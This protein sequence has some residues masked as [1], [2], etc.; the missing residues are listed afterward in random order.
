MSAVRSSA[1]LLRADL[2]SAGSGILTIPAVLLV[3]YCGLF[4]INLGMVLLTA[5][6][7]L[8]SLAAFLSAVFG[9][10][11]APVELSPP[12]AARRGVRAGMLTLLVGGAT[13]VLLTTFLS[14]GF[15]ESSLVAVPALAVLLPI[16][17][18]M[19]LPVLLAAMLFGWLGGWLE[20]QGR[21]APHSSDQSDL[22][23]EPE[24]PTTKP[25]LWKTA[26][27]YIFIVSGLCYASPLV[28]L[29]IPEP[30]EEIAVEPTPP[31]PE[32]VPPVEPERE[33]PPP[34]PPPYKYQRPAGFLEAGAERITI[35]QREDYHGILTN[36][37]VSISP[38][39]AMLAFCHKRLR[40]VSV[41]VIRLDDRQQVVSIPLKDLPIGLAW[42]QDSQRLLYIANG[43][44]RIAGV[45]SLEDAS[46]IELPIPY[47]QRLPNQANMVWPFEKQVA[48]FAPRFDPA[49][50]DLDT[51]RVH[52]LIDSEPWEELS[53]ERKLVFQAMARGDH[54][55][56]N[57][58]L[59][60]PHEFVSYYMPPNHFLG[61]W[62]QRTNGQMAVMD[63]EFAYT[64]ILPFRIP[65]R[66]DRLIATPDRSIFVHLHDDNAQ[67]L[68]LGLRDAPEL[69]VSVPITDLFPEPI[70]LEVEN[71]L[72]NKVLAAFVC[73]PV[74]N[75]L[76]NEVV[77]PDRRR[78]RAM[79]R[80]AMLET[81]K[82]EL[83]ISE[84][85]ERVRKGDVVADLHYWQSNQ[86]HSLEDPR[87]ED[88]WKP[89]PPGTPLE[90][91]LL[92][93]RAE[94]PRRSDRVVVN[95]APSI[96]GP[97]PDRPGVEAKATPEG[98]IRNFILEHHRMLSRRDLDGIAG[99]YAANVDY[100]DH[101]VVTSQFIREDQKKYQDKYSRK[102]SETIRGEIA[103]R[104]TGNQ[105]YEARYELFSSVAGKEE[106]RWVEAT[107]DVVLKIRLVGAKPVITSQRA[108]VRDV[109]HGEP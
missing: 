42:S 99:N 93:K 68:Y 2:F 78:I 90:S 20:S 16:L 43:D 82:V 94:V 21:T 100:F 107:S 40:G 37:P 49:F 38:D 13:L 26:L 83:W 79:V 62:I 12:L 6:A 47:A 28:S 77:G 70:L 32:P 101:G 98:L 41:V 3:A 35:T 15:F 53:E 76:N 1:S 14:F 60:A 71:H 95:R 54:Y 74:T 30:Q 31:P 61:N 108:N 18:M 67:F 36:A 102:V 89:M 55:T 9:D 50:L 52:P 81:D 51:L 48:I 103:L 8:A 39:S 69:R 75:P 33:P 57:R 5:L 64:H 87:L 7:A 45:L 72:K 17:G 96:R 109:N 24:A 22:D 84:E 104:K 80:M 29:L 11:S 4:G 97:R 86:P 44:P 58:W 66:G 91:G 63:Q 46:S 10:R 27:P 25:S 56:N 59:I 92:A 85:Y 105:L 19:L 88:W 73:P 34:P 65:A 23:S 106:W